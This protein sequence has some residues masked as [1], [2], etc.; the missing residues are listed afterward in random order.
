M[1]HLY[2][3][4]VKAGIEH[5][6]DKLDSVRDEL[7]GQNIQ[8]TDETVIHVLMESEK[9]LVILQQRIKAME[10]ERKIVFKQVSGDMLL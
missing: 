2:D 3:G 9:M 1:L 4:S 7:N 6:Q 8:M 5:L 10:Y